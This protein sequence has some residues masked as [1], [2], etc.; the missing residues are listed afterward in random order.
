MHFT[1][2]GEAR[3]VLRRAEKS[4]CNPCARGA[5]S[6]CTCTS[7][8]EFSTAVA[9]PFPAGP[10]LFA[11]QTAWILLKSHWGCW[12]ELPRHWLHPQNKR[13]ESCFLPT[14]I[15]LVLQSASRRA[16]L[17]GRTHAGTFLEVL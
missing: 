15:S 1:W 8:C 16:Q 13:A 2:K 14:S 9:A 10:R 17:T 4:S 12:W 11:E 5:V 6:T 7:S 3:D